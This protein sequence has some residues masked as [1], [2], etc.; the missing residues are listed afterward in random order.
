MLG[1]NSAIF[2]QDFSVVLEY[3]T[4]NK[5]GLFFEVGDRNNRHSFNKSNLKKAIRG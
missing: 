5:M 2:N 1:T 3:E 4:E